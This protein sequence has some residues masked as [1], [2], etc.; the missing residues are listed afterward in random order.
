[1]RKGEVLAL[2]GENGSGKTTLSKLLTGL[3]LPSEGAVTWDGVRA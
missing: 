2:V 1:M 3:Y